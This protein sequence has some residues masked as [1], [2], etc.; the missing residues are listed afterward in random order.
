MIRVGTSGWQY[1][2]WRGTFYP[3]DLPKRQWL[4]VCS[5]RFSTIEVNNTFYRL[6]ERSTFERW[7]EETPDGF[8]FTVKASRYLTHVRRLVDPEEPV[9]RLWERALGLGPRLGPVLFQL[10]P[11]FKFDLDRLAGLF[12]VLPSSMRPALEFRDVSWDRPEVNEMLDRYGAAL[13]WADPGPIAC[14]RATG[15]WLYMR[16]H[17]ADFDG[18]WEYGREQ[19]RP[20]AERIAGSDAEEVFVYFN[21]D[22][23]AAAIRDADTMIELL[24]ELV[25]GRMPPS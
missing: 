5:R 9:Q 3:E 10:P 1:D 14:E 22:P 12:E 13:G 20:W 11:N 23:G 4:Q 18:S 17:R 16:F 6:P 7:R 24:T 19:L 2:D 15:G 21:N 8:C 25:P